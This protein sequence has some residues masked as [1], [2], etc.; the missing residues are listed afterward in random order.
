MMD[1]L[2][3]FKAYLK[4]NCNNDFARITQPD[5]QEDTI[6][7]IKSRHESRYQVWQY[8]SRNAPWIISLYNGK[9]PSEVFSGQLPI[10]NFCRLAEELAFQN[11]I[12]KD[13]TVIA[14]RMQ[15]AENLPNMVYGINTREGILAYE[16][17]LQKAGYS[18][19]NTRRAV[20]RRKESF[21]FCGKL[22]SCG[23]SKKQAV[24]VLKEA[25]TINI[26]EQ[27]ELLNTAVAK[28]QTPEAKKQATEQ[29]KIFINLHAQYLYNH[30]DELQ[31]INGILSAIQNNNDGKTP[32]SNGG[33]DGDGKTPPGGGGGNGDGKGPPPPPGGGGGCI[34][35]PSN[36]EKNSNNDGKTPPSDGGN[37]GDDGN[38]PP[39]GG[40]GGGFS[41]LCSNIYDSPTIFIPASKAA[42][43]VKEP[44]NIEDE[45]NIYKFLN[46]QIDNCVF[47]QLKILD[48]ALT[49]KR[50][51]RS[52]TP[53]TAPL[54][55]IAPLSADNILLESEPFAQR[56]LPDTDVPLLKD[57][58]HIS[59]RLQNLNEEYLR[60]HAQFNRE[61]QQHM[62]Q[63]T[64]RISTARS[65]TQNLEDF[66]NALYQSVGLQSPEIS[67]GRH[68]DL[69]TTASFRDYSR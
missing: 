15:Y 9:L 49:T 16:S 31:K 4:G 45:P 2:E 32:P 23:I 57:H 40:G 63:L 3:D 47:S 19:E 65:R 24:S 41:R 60:K 11:L 46:Q 38:E 58:I 1:D 29:L 12:Y 26:L 50:E 33:N 53:D 39:G 42:D 55:R 52:Q 21:I 61:W 13:N 56:E 69:C 17:T 37:D 10:E 43:N 54:N 48:N 28:A 27:L 67:A 64:E 18:Q 34:P 22:E 7:A 6:N 30:P 62:Q 59:Q 35:F 8:I 66:T 44:Q 51:R 68:S 20:S 25:E 36:E 5:I 14:L